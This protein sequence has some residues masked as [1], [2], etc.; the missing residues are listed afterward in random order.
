MYT[1]NKYVF[2]HMNKTG[3]VFVKDYLIKYMDA[4][5]YK[6]KHSPIRMLEQ[7]HH[8]KTKIG[9]IRNPFSW[10]V[11]YYTYLTKNKVLTTMDFPQ[12]LFTYTQHPRALLDFMG[13]KIRRKYENLYPPRTKLPIGSWT[14]HFINYF[15]Y[16]AN[17]IF[18]EEILA[19][20]DPSNLDVLMRTETLKEDMIKVFGEEHRESIMNLPKKNVSNAKPY[21]E[22]YTPELRSFVEQRDG[23]LMEYLGYKYD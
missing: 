15:S 4:K 9:V 10:Y 12:F 17:R 13:R 18:K 23:T 14:F 16:D 21:Q 20:V 11:S 7:K 8:N 2:I 22:Y 5:V 6:Y 3:G 1:T 19:P